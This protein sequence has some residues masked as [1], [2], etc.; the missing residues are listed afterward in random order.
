MKAYNFMMEFGCNCAA[1]ISGVESLA[2]RASTI[3]SKPI[4][5]IMKTKPKRTKHGLV[6]KSDTGVKSL[7]R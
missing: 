4:K 6:K 2:T 7:V 5:S 1:G 3:T